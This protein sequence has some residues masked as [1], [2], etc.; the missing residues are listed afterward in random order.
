MRVFAIGDIHGAYKALLQCLRRSSFDYEKDRLIVLGDVCDGYI[1]VKQS[2]DELLK[3]KHCDF[4]I[5]NHDLWALGWANRGEK[6]EIWLTQ[7]GEQTIA[8]YA[9]GP[10]PQSHIDFLKNAHWWIEFENKLFVHGGIDPNKKIEKQGLEYLSW[11]RSL[12][13]SAW[14]K[15]HQNPKY[16]FSTYDEI[17][18]GHTT[19]Q[20]MA[21]NKSIKGLAAVEAEG[22]GTK[23]LFLSNIIMLDTGAGW[24]GKLTIMDV[25]SHEYWQSD[26][27]H[28]LQGMEGRR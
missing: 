12:V 6:P 4:I 21:R 18:V 16:K 8:S 24:S 26:F 2:I 19:T 14:N 28:L 22:L 11:D 5:G 10:M 9:G 13:E 20:W 27:T 1:E 7:G 25:N 23:P 15:A 3:I 17:F